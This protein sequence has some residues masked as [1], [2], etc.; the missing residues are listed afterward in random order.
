MVQHPLSGSPLP[1]LLRILL[2]SGG[3]DSKYRLKLLYVLLLSALGIPFRAIESWRFGRQIAATTLTAPPIFVLGHWRSGTTHLHRLMAQDKNLGYVSSLQ[4]FMPESF[5][6]VQQSQYL[7]LGKL[8]PKMRLMDNVSYAPDVPEEEEYALGNV[9]PL[10]FYH[11]WY[12]PRRMKEI[13]RQSVLLEDISDDLK[14]EW[15]AAF[16]KI[17]KKTTIEYG[18]KRLVVKNPA[19]T[20]RIS[21]LLELF[22]DAKFIHIYR[23]PY[24]VYCSTKHFYEKLLPHYTFQEIDAIALEENI[25]LFYQQLMQRYFATVEAIPPE[26][27]IEITYEDFDDN[28][29]E[30]LKRIYKKLEIPNFEAAAAHFKTYVE[31]HAQYKK[32][33]YSLDDR[34]RATIDQHWGF[35]IDRWHLLAQASQIR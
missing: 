27:L 9:L 17:L 34:T 16:L 7:D 31:K 3:I 20:A 2:R 30:S 6:S 21:F 33:S 12:F 19:N 10:S 13:Y 28:E 11:C 4:A 18:G 23:N 22:P 5:L 26:N 1:V 14:A 8:W 29:L 25:L 15:Q 32:N 24:D 35:A